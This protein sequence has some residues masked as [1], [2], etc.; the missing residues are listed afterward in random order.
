MIKHSTSLDQLWLLSLLLTLVLFIKHLPLT[1]ARSYPCP[2]EQ[3]VNITDGLRLKD[4]SYS[5][6]GLVIPANLTAQYSFKVIDGIEYDAPTHLRGCACLLKPCITFCCPSNMH[7]DEVHQNCTLNA[8]E[9]HS[10]HTHIEVTFKNGTIDV[11]NIKNAFIVRYEFGCKTK[12]IE[13][14]KDEFW[15][16]DLFENGTL[17]RG[18]K[19]YTTDEYCFTPLEHKKAWSLTPLTCERYQRGLKV[20]IYVICTSVAIIINITVILMFVAI[21]DVRNSNYGEGLIFH[22]FA[23]TIGLAALV[24]LQLKNPLNLS[25]TACRNIGFLA[26]FFLIVS[27]LILNIISGNF[28]ATF[29]LKPIKSWHL[30]ILYGLT[31]A[32]AFG[33]KYLAKF[34]QDSNI[35]RYLKPGIGQDY[36][37]FDIRLWGILL[38]FYLPILISLILSLY[39]AIRAYFSIFHL[40]AD[41]LNVGG[42]D[43]KTTKKHFMAYCIYL[44]VVFSIWMREIIVYITARFR[45]VFFIIDYWSGICILGLAAVAFIFLL[46]RN[47]FVRNWWG[48]NVTGPPK[49]YDYSLPPSFSLVHTQDKK[50][51]E[52]VIEPEYT[53][54]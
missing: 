4:G 42:K 8:K 45:Q 36:C 5:F 28:W 31:L 21:K 18:S 46:T 2:Y 26:Y 32:V 27:F 6:E 44:L 15:K 34:A 33:L 16:W 29:A 24:Y 23:L 14:K 10:Q 37:W 48:I 50:P 9:S 19:Y 30:K 51:T 7:Y 35:A 12:Y 22:L 43:F 39:C 54:N 25:H 47:I 53:G 17:K 3:T 41:T 20:W 52:I 40:P 11:V 38:Y 49:E 13:K 1:T